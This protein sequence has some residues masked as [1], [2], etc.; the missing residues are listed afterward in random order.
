MKKQYRIITLVI[1]L[2]L[3]VLFVVV[4]GVYTY[5]TATK[6]MNEKWDRAVNNEA[7]FI[8]HGKQDVSEI[9][10]D[11]DV[12]RYLYYDFEIASGMKDDDIGYYEVYICDDG[13][14]IEPVNHIVVSYAPNGGSLSEHRFIPVDSNSKFRN[15]DRFTPSKIDALCDNNFIF[16]GTIEGISWIYDDLEYTIG[17]NDLASDEDTVHVHEWI[18][19]IDNTDLPEDI[20]NAFTQSSVASYHAVV[21]TKYEKK[22][23]DEAKKKLEE[24][25]AKTEKDSIF[26]EYSNGKYYYYSVKYPTDENESLSVSYS[27]VASNDKKVVVHAQKEL[28]T[29]FLISDAAINSDTDNTY[30]IYLFHP[31]EITFRNNIKKYITSLIVFV[32]LEILVVIIMRKM[33]SNRMKYELMRQGLTRSI[34]HDLKTPLAIT[35]AYTENW[36]Y[37]DE[38]D[39]HAYAER[40]NSEVDNMASIINDMI[41]IS[42]LDSQ[43]DLKRQAVELYSMTSEI[44][45]QMKPIISERG[46]DVRFFAD[47]DDGEYYA[48]ADPKMMKLVISNFITNA[49]KYAESVIRIELYGFHKK[50]ISFVITN[51]GQRIKRKDIRK[52]WEPF[53]KGDKSRTDRIGSSG[54][55]LA[56]NSSILKLHKAKYKCTSKKTTTFSFE[57]KKVDKNG[58]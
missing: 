33:Y 54:M 10:S 51:D 44:L 58:K 16:N 41:N 56:I 18:K 21:E 11:N 9:N 49:V 34:A 2:L 6:I 19:Q 52:I 42:K 32:L 15:Q 48:Y 25:L 22:L 12:I 50:R 38:K 40:L 30:V 45:E 3:L 28:G 36:E 1:N 35:K 24:T 29:S 4:E 5:E 37:I 47:K 27:N 57:I 14:K 39:R 20:D 43:Q 31:L 23:C 17:E 46:L 26:K 7:F 55:G 53:F 13:K 8:T